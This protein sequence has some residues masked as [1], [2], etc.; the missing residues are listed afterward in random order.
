MGNG[1]ES[2]GGGEV[3]TRPYS[4][5]GMGKNRG[6]GEV[7]TRPYSG[8]RCTVQVLK[9]WFHF[10]P[11]NPISIPYLNYCIICIPDRIMRASKIFFV[12][13]CNF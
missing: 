9:P 2:G 13:S 10:R 4:E 1:E 5:W 12:R 3:G 8:W 11:K 6:G 7:G